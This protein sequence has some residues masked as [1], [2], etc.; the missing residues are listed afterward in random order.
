MRRTLL[1]WQRSRLVSR[2]VLFNG[3]YLILS[4]LAITLLMM[5]STQY[6]PLVQL[7]AVMIDVARPVMMTLRSPVQAADHARTFVDQW[8]NTVQENRQ[9]KADNQAL[10]QW[11]EKAQKLMVENQGLRAMMSY[12]PA[13]P[14]ALMS[15]AVLSHVASAAQRHMVIDVG[16]DQGVKKHSA[17]IAAQ[18]LVG[19]VSEVGQNAARV[20][21]M[22]DVNSRIP[23]FIGPQLQTAILAGDG[24]DWPKLL[25]VE[26][27]D[28]MALRERVVTSGHGGFFQPGLWVGEVMRDSAGELRVRPY[29]DWVRLSYVQLIQ[30]PSTTD[31]TA[32][33]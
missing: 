29:V 23:V 16:Q 6:A 12:R 20:M 5:D 1:R 26:N 2:A 32:T 18:G 13:P 15:A 11:Y 30:L 7:R 24:T 10:M 27:A 28:Q 22:T 8:V 4:A 31:E 14:E 19:L 3:S 25:Y 9:L 17:A 33:R 21:L